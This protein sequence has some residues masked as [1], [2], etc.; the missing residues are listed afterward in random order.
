MAT[1]QATTTPPIFQL[2]INGRCGKRRVVVGWAMVPD[3]D[4]TRTELLRW[5]WSLNIA[6]YPNRGPVGIPRKIVFLHHV[7]YR[8]HHGEMPAGTVIDHIDRNPL[9]ALPSNLRAVNPAINA[10]NRGRQS[11][12]TSGFQGVFWLKRERRWLAKIKAF[13]RYYHLGLYTDPKL[14]A[15]A[16]NRAY[17]EHFPQVPPPN[18]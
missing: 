15:A 2:P 17:A 5:S 8:Q 11:N 7:I 10:A 9:N 16:V 4:F 1:D 18:A 3:D 12:N 14:A 13:G 6:G